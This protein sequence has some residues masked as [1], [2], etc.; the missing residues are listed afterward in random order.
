M[1]VSVDQSA[2]VASRSSP[3][4]RYIRMRNHHFVDLEEVPQPRAEGL[5]HPRVGVGESDLALG[6]GSLACVRAV[7]TTRNS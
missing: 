1:P 2:F 6:L 5:D 7:P 4:C 3:S